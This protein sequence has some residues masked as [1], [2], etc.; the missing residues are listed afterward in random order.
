M[1][2]YFTLE[3]ARATLPLVR[4]LLLEARAQKRR[5]DDLR[6]A[7][8]E[9]AA[10]TLGN[11]HLAPNGNGG[12]R[13]EAEDLVAALRS[14]IQR[15][16][17]MGCLVKDLD[18]GLADWPSLRDGREVYLCWRLGEPDILN[19]HEPEAGFAGRQPL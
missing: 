18:S 10:K 9:T 3:E 14:T 17:A 6:I 12:T 1:P 7:L 5:L 2:R 13:A 19:W 8:A 15:I 16:E 11:G 4:A